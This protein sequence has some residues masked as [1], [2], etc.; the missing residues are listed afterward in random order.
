[1]HELEGLLDSIGKIIP[2]AHDA[3]LEPSYALQEPGRLYRFWRD[4]WCMDVAPQPHIEMAN[5][6]D[7]ALGDRQF[8]SGRQTLLMLGVPRGTYKTT[9][10]SE[11]TPVEILTRNSNAKILLDGFR[12]SISKARLRAIRRQIEGSDNLDILHNTRAWKPGFREDTWND[13]EIFIT[14]RTDNM[15]REASIATAG[16]D[17]SMNSQ[18]FDVIIA[19]DVVTDTNVQTA[20]GRE[21]VYQHI[22]DL[23]PILNPGGVLILVFTTWHPDDA[24]GRII[25]LDED[26][27]RRGL[28][29][30]WRKLIR[31]AY[32]GPQGLFAPTILSV[33]SLEDLRERMGTRKFAA[34]YLL[35]P[36]A[37]EDRVFNM[38]NARKR[39][40]SFFSVYGRPYGGLI[41][42]DNGEQ[43]DVET[44]LAWDP[45]GRKQSK[46]SDSHGLTVVGT[47]SRDDW[48]CLEAM[49]VKAPPTVIIDRVCRLIQ[50]Y[51]P[52]AVSI[53][54]TFGSGLWIDLLYEE[55][56]RRGMSVNVVEYTTGGVPKN[57][58]IVGLQ[59]RWERRGF[60]LRLNNENLPMH[61][62]FERQLENFTVGRAMDHEDIIDSLV[63]HRGN[64]R[65]PSLYPVTLDSNPVDPEY[66][67]FR[68]RKDAENEHSGSRSGRYGP[69]WTVG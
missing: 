65:R 61:V 21:R 31:G 38:D 1:M 25:R 11:A 29:P 17:R 9:G 43:V 12:H 55:L 10:V 2:A 19:D 16:V 3:A 20:E 22:Q 23:L 15:S 4:S 66:E 63:Q 46:T 41:R 36:V 54:D 57:E 67:E 42:T 62:V 59:P 64:T 47:D 40:F 56:S 14:T 13:E 32:D 24:Y 37:D 39:K 6:V 5:F 58:R 49:A 50:T 27:V 8:K 48:W 26:R 52:H 45:A 28:E 18:H 35:K 30:H 33:D 44:T 68:K 51:N 60:I 69:V 7:E 34:Q 53:E